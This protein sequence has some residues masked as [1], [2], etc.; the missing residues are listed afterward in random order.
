MAN[1]TN[2]IQVNAASGTLTNG[3]YTLITNVTARTG[4]GTF[5]FAN[6]ST[7]LGNLWLTN[8]PN[9]VVLA[10]IGDTPNSGSLVWRG[11]FNGIWD[12]TTA[13]WFDGVATTF[14]DGAYVMFDDTASQFTLSSGGGSPAG[15]TINS[16]L[17]TY[18]IASV[19][20]GAG[21]LNK[22]GT[23]N[24]TLSGSNT[25]AGPTALNSGGT[26]TFNSLAN[27][28]GGASSFG[29]P[30]TTDNG[31]ITLNNVAPHYTGVADSTSDRIINAV[32]S[33]SFYNDSTTG[34]LILTSPMT[35]GNNSTI[36][37]RGVGTIVAGGFT[38]FGSGGIQHNDTGT[39]ILTNQLNLFTGTPAVLNG[40]IYIDKIA[41]SGVASPLGAGSQITLG[42]TGGAATGTLQLAVTNGSSCNGILFIQCTT[43]GGGAIEN[44]VAGTTVT[45]SGMVTNATTNI[46]TSPVLQLLGVGD[47]VLS[48]VIGATTNT[49][50]G[51]AITKAGSGN[52]TLSGVNTNKG[53]TTVSGGKLLINSD[54]TA[55][56]N[57]WTVSAGGTLG[58]TGV[59]G[60]PVT[61][62]SGSYLAPGGLA[63]R[64][65]LT[66]TNGLG[67][68]GATLNFTL[69]NAVA[70][71][72]TYDQLAVTNGVFVANGV[73]YIQIFVPTGTLTNGTYVL[74]T[75]VNARTGSGSFVFP[76][77][78]TTNWTV[79]A[80]TLQL[81]TNANSVKL[82]VS[83]DTAFNSLSWKG[84]VSGVWDALTANWFNGGPAIFADGVPVTF[85]DTAIQYNLTSGGGSPASVTFNNNA[86]NY[87]NSAVIGGTGGL[88]KNGSAS[89]FL[90][91]ASTYTGPTVI[92]SANVSFNTLGNVNGSASSFGQPATTNNG[93]IS[94]GGGANLRFTSALAD[95]ASDRIINAV[96]SISLY[97][98]NTNGSKLILTGGITNNSILFRGVGTIVVSGR[99]TINAN[100]LVKTD[101]G[102][103]VLTN[104]LNPFTGAMQMSDGKTYIDTIAN[105]TVPCSIGAGSQITLG[106]YGGATT[107]TL[108]LAVPNGSSSDR[109][110]VVQCP[111]SGGGT[112]EN[113]LAGNTVTFS[114]NVTFQPTNSGAVILPVLTLTGVGNGVL[115]GTIGINA[116]LL[117]SPPIVKSGAG[118]WTLSGLN[119]NRGTVTVSAGT[120]LINGDSSGATN[121]W[122]VNNGGTLGGT[123]KI[124][125]RVT[126]NTGGAL[127]PGGYN[128]IGTLTLTNGLA[129]NTSFLYCDLSTNAGASD[130]VVIS[131]NLSYSGTNNIV[132]NFPLGAAPAGTNIL[133]T[134]PGTNGSPGNFYL[135][136]TYTNVLLVVT[137]TN[138]QLVVSNGGTYANNLTWNGNLSG[139]WDTGTANWVTNGVPG[140]IYAEGNSVLFDDTSTNFSVSGLAVAPNVV[141]VNATN[142]Y[143][144]ANAITNPAATVV[145]LN[146]GILTLAADNTF[147]NNLVLNS[148]GGVIQLGAGGTSGNLGLVPFL[149]IGSVPIWF[150]RTDPVSAPFVFSNKI[151]SSGGFVVLSGAVQIGGAADN[152]SFTGTVASGATLILAKASASNVHSL[153]GNVTVSNNA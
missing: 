51:L 149:N 69:T 135:L 102:T 13:N 132:L 39:L 80:V 71:G 52:W 76:A 139:T 49:A 6:G 85:D 75:N 86:N 100:G 137:T 90:F 142:N 34:K 16:Y 4:T 40:N 2:Y 126:A 33:I 124:G 64:G 7:N 120:L 50:V 35:N 21:G 67:L 121:A 37:F 72:T 81:A 19:I 42:Q 24:L 88:T 114:G 17:N 29:A 62:V 109:S 5:V 55:V 23:A 56:T 1:G 118:T 84:A 93:I 60:G 53:V 38:N 28:G 140:A 108:Q 8:G 106:Q 143:T 47:G 25:Y 10:V 14:A 144:I 105:S 65:K 112:I 122:T 147:T 111:A 133:M 92:N 57:L 103:L 87:T 131:N 11:A 141:T 130:R 83:G 125:G 18:T 148:G 74:I 12:T 31:I 134:Y 152:T 43:S 110:I 63:A 78:G 116:N 68:N 15:V 101:T 73:N 127:A 46:V 128:A 44:T 94:V 129:L 30:A 91:G 59:I 150:N 82:V 146:T 9:S 99:I 151:T 54:H 79:G 58:G 117:A 77:T 26:V 45:F 70:A 153:G 61:N 41:N 98:D 145:K 22:I 3:T 104:A 32:N 27:V 66:L 89:L 119:T 136:G 95:A 20:G 97:N 138:V 113:T 107:G 96:S 123:N 115:S 48:G 36:T